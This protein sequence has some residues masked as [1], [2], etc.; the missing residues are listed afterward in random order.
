MGYW[1]VTGKERDVKSSS[2]VIGTKRTLVFHIGRAPKGQR[3]EWLMHEYCMK[4][5]VYMVH[6]SEVQISQKKK[7]NYSKVPFF[8]VV[9]HYIIGN[10][11]YLNYSSLCLVFDNLSS[12]NFLG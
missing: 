7:K 6:Y 9:N 4:G 3:T 11:G 12:V 5:G 2:Q 10:F 8:V 1:K